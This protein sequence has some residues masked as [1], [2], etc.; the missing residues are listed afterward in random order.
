MAQDCCLR[1]RCC[2]QVDD[3]EYFVICCLNLQPAA[4]QCWLCWDCCSLALQVG[5][6]G[7]QAP[8]KRMTACGIPK[9]WTL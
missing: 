2:L 3:T 4:A 5:Q 1:A 8:I 7:T 6:A 9:C